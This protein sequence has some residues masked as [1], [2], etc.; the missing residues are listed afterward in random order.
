VRRVRA[1][2]VGAVMQP[3]AFRRLRRA[4]GGTI[5]ITQPKPTTDA[6]G[7][8][9]AA[10][11]QLARRAAVRARGDGGDVTPEQAGI[12]AG[13]VPLRGSALMAPAQLRVQ[14]C[15]HDNVSRLPLSRARLPL[16]LA[17]P[18]VR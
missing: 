14:F 9:A 17:P 5:T 18:C 16:F 12:D 10:A 8:T 13:C 7:A 2:A 1:A 3:L 11:A 6:R 15:R 4:G